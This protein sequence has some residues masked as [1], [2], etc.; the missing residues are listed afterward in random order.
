MEKCQCRCQIEQFCHL[1]PPDTIEHAGSSPQLHWKLFL[2]DWKAIELNANEIAEVTT[3]RIQKIIYWYVF[4]QFFN[5]FR[6]Y[7]NRTIK[8]RKRTSMNLNAKTNFHA[9]WQRQR[10][11]Q[12]QKE[13]LKSSPCKCSFA[14][15]STFKTCRRFGS[16]LCFTDFSSFFFASIEK[17]CRSTIVW[18]GFFGV[19]LLSYVPC[20]HT[21]NPH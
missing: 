3:N 14:K 7:N 10:R 19:K 11:T 2:Y 9:K 16:F 13:N 21:I 8:W 17:R 20:Y 12:K 4:K 6:M 18:V 5:R 15:C 1:I